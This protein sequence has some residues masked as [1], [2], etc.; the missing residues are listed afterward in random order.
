MRARDEWVKMRSRLLATRGAPSLVQESQ[1]FLRGTYAEQ[2]ARETQ[3]IPAWTVLNTVAHG[4]LQR[5]HNAARTGG[6]LRWAYPLGW[7]RASRELAREISELVG[8]DEALLA[9]LQLAVLVPVELQFMKDHAAETD[10]T[11]AVAWARAALRSSS[12]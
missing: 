10:V 6:P 12:W 2:V 11:A 1:A 8:D 9:S 4:D 3:S 5:I 7:S